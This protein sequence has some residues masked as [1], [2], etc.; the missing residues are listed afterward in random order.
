MEYPNFK[1]GELEKIFDKFETNEKETINDFIKYCGI[2][3][4]EI[5]QKDIKRSII[6]FRYLV[7]KK[8]KDIDLESLR[9]YLTLLNKSNRKPYTQNG[10]KTH[11]KR[12]LKWN[13]K[14][15]WERFEELR[16]IRLNSKPKNTEKINAST[17]L[18]KEEIESLMKS[19]PRLFW[20]TFLITLY[21][22]GCRPIELRELK[23]KDIKF[24]TRGDI[25]ELKIYS[26]KTKNTRFAYIN[27]ATP[28]LLKLK[29][30]SK[31][32]LVFPSPHSSKSGGIGKNAV[33]Q[34]LNKL[35]MK[36]IGRHITP[37][38]LRHTRA[39]ELYVLRKDIDNKEV[40]KWLGHSKSM[41]D[42]YANMSKED[43]EKMAE[44]L[45]QTEFTPE[46]KNE[47]EKQ[48]EELKKTNKQ[49]TQGMVDIANRLDKIE[50]SKA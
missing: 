16:D 12:F 42:I 40:E 4:S 39:R 30:E 24:N 49:L 21:E 10:I 48:I 20:K 29:E 44:T 50:K 37:Y 1:S 28:Y 27:T 11:I 14:D 25:S 41:Y 6:Q 9:E 22:S 46:Q 15:W 7:N 17:L 8:I 3:C 13:F 5:K 43:V 32:N 18:T 31:S 26:G 35:S 23:W 38:F 45:Y 33:C 19:E 34:W 47:Y 36:S 2:N